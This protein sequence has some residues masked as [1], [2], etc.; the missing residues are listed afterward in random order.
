MKSR[1]S[2]SH[3]SDKFARYTFRLGV[4]W[5]ILVTLYANARESDGSYRSW[6]EIQR[7]KNMFFVGAAIAIGGPT[8][9]L[10]ISNAI[11]RREARR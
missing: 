5:M 2:K 4:A 10:A 8:A 1:V 11:K 7:H 3:W 6:D 9:S